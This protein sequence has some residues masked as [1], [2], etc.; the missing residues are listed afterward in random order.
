MRYTINFD[1]KTHH[2]SKDKKIPILLRVSINGV[3]DYLNTGKRIKEIHYDKEN[4]CV[5]S[6]IAGFS[7]I[8][9][10]I[11]RQKVRVENI[12]SDFEKKGE[13]ATIAKIKEIYEQE[14]GK[15]KSDS[16]YDFVEEKIKWERANTNKSSDTLDNYDSQLNKLKVYK[17]KLTIHDINVEFLE[18][19]KTYILE[20]LQQAD[21]TAYHA[22]CF[23]R[24]Y[25]KILFDDGKIRP[26]PFAKFQVGS[27]FEVEPEYLEPEE[28]TQLHDLYDSK[29]LVKITR[30]ATNKYSKYKEFNIG[31]KYQ[32]VLKYFLVACYTGLRH[33]D[34][35]TLRRDNIKGKFVVKEMIKGR[36]GRKK[37]VRIP[38]RKRL[39]SLIDN[40]KGLL[41]EN[42]VM[43]DSQTNKY[44]KAIM[45]VAEIDK[46]ITFHCAR[47]TFSII[48]LLLGIKIEVVSDILGHSELTTTQRYARVVDRL[49]ELEMDKWDKMAKE[50]FNS[51]SLHD[52]V[53]PNCGNSV[54]KFE[55]GIITLNKIPMICPYCSTSFS[56][57]LKDIIPELNRKQLE[58][59]SI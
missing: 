39:L 31:D 55:K 57:N 38:I 13:V 18:K 24:K 12:I 11:D 6:G 56:Y 23:L 27:P 17:S 43:E 37:T 53:C 25:T 9:S 49:R 30:I 7:T 34:I 45:E 16:F 3:H 5:K 47:H 40:S 26:Y 46:H 15:V 20:T 48:S 14:T 50:E 29:K 41:F 52:I 19:Y 54:L 1:C 2:I 10:F 4:K 35:K 51:D 32:E 8:T 44:L 22:M 28:L 42:P 33:S 59:S 36:E 21:N 58:Y